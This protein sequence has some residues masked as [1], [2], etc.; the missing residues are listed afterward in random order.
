MDS[1]LAHPATIASVRP[2]PS[3]IASNSVWSS[4]WCAI[5]VSLFQTSIC[6]KKQSQS[7]LNTSPP[8]SPLGRPGSA[9]QAKRANLLLT[10]KEVY[11]TIAT[12]RQSVSGPFGSSLSF[13]NL[14]ES[15]AINGAAL[16]R[17]PNKSGMDGAILAESDPRIISKLSRGTAVSL[18][19]STTQLIPSD[20]PGHVDGSFYDERSYIRAPLNSRIHPP[21]AKQSRRDK[22]VIPIGTLPVGIQEYLIME[23]MLFGI[24]GRY[25]QIVRS[26][27]DS[28][29]EDMVAQPTVPVPQYDDNTWGT[30]NF[31]IDPSLDP[32]LSDLVERILPVSIYYMSADAFVQ[33]HSQSEYGL[34][35]HALCAA[36][37]GLLKLEHQFRSSPSF[38][39]QKFWFYVQPTLQTMSVIHSLCNL[40]RDAGVDTKDDDEDEDEIEAVLEGLS[41]TAQDGIKAPEM[42]KGGAI[43]TMLADRLVGMSGDPITKKLHTYLLSQSSIPYLS[44][45]DAWIHHG[46]IRDPHGE[47]M[48]QEK[49][50]VKK[51]NLKEDFNDAYWEMRY[52][53]RDNAV[54]AFLEPLSKKILLA[55]KYLNVI[56]ECGIN[57]I[58]PTMLQGAE[59]EDENAA[60]ASGTAEVEAGEEREREGGKEKEK[61]KEKEREGFGGAGGGSAIREGFDNAQGGEEERPARGG[62][63][64]RRAGRGGRGEVS[65]VFEGGGCG[66]VMR[67]VDRCGVDNSMA[68][69]I[70]SDVC[71]R[72]MCYA[73]KT[74]L[75]M[76]LKNQQLIPRLRS[77]KHYFF[78]DQSDFLTPF[79]DVAKEELKKPHREVS[80]TRLQSL[81]DLV[82]RNPS[83]V[84]AYDPFKEDVKVQMSGLRLIDQLL[85]II[86]VN[87]LE[88]ATINSLAASAAGKD[89]KWIGAATAGLKENLASIRGSLADYNESPAASVGP[90]ASER[91]GAKEVKEV[92][93][94]YDALTL[95]YHV[96]FPLSLV[97]SRKALTKYQLLFRHLLYLKHVEGLLS[98]TWLDHKQPIWRRPSGS[99]EIDRFKLR[100]FAL[101]NRMLVFV[102]QFA[103][104][105]TSEVLEPNWRVLE[106]NLAKV[107]VRVGRLMACK[108]VSTVDQV[109]QY[110][111]DFLDTCL[112]ECML[113]NAK[114]LR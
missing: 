88:G 43:L 114:L 2:V 9:A 21:S 7:A 103:Y 89:A 3:T 74:L 20:P 28:D 72:G 35:S 22:P 41:G 65:V 56:R 12:A 25:V 55:G 14:A 13:E 30:V 85:R 66:V 5:C 84:A 81:L 33:L 101:R 73:N 32:S 27:S 44:I 110:H 108:G 107:G 60:M 63:A 15:T 91:A 16:S 36:I 54:P 86:S 67:L 42:Q 8:T 76:L 31:W 6:S 96:T 70:S 47:F 106:M 48:V 64:E 78:L 57:I 82:L 102:Q 92:L 53:P 79:L 23:D 97:I 49:K 80:L 75:D 111:S 34:V 29:E 1:K 62:G 38:T 46:E 40:I 58:G 83:S 17:S 99:G 26:N 109:L 24:D 69:S 98:D 39:L 11:K 112:K 93:T 77:L 50:N 113:T 100:V 95:D 87:G 104:Y 51:E 68:E 61:E 45:L 10:Q 4:S 19:D 71:V 59:E 105:V 52:T 37:R 94:G 18:R 90:G